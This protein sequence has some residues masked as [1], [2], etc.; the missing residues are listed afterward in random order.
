MTRPVRIVSTGA[1]LPET[2]LSS[3]DIDLRIG[4]NPGFVEKMT[5]IR[6]RRVATGEDQVDLAVRAARQA[7]DEAG[8]AFRPDH[9]LFAAAV[10]YQSI[11][12][13]AP[14]IMQRLGLEP[15]S[16]ACFDINATCLSFLAAADLAASMIAGGSAKSV[17]VVSS[18]IASRALPWD[19]A[20]LTAAL[21]GDG[22][23]AAL[24]SS[25]EA[26]GARFLASLMETYPEGY[27][28]CRLG[29][30]GTR[31]DFHRSPDEFAANSLFEMD[32]KSLYRITFQHFESFLHRLLG[33]AG[34][35][36]EDVDLVLPHQ[37]SI[38][39]LAHLVDQCGFPQE[40]VIDL[41]RIYGNQVAAS[42]PV[43][44][45]HARRS[46]RLKEG[47]RVLMVGTSAGLSLGGLALVT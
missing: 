28:A 16:A 9:I 5:G 44:L 4:R 13:T 20:P 33:R 18:E 1:C 19:D 26:G 41:M 40:R 21:F 14:L 46:G 29:A 15:G 12:A 24:L 8:F 32:G 2:I 35:A 3:T 7:L 38:R 17:L 36:I 42:L 45:D 22:A 47:M 25:S 27:D 43:V 31:Y 6:E 30:G 10:P 11:P 34:W 23:A 39:A 37:A